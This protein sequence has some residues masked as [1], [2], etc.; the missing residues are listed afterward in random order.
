MYYNWGHQDLVLWV[1]K[2]YFY[3][4]LPKVMLCKMCGCINQMSKQGGS[5]NFSISLT[6]CSFSKKKNT[7]KREQLLKE[8]V[9]THQLVI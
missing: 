5:F 2:K 8:C 4:N 3:Y 7:V 9:F 1:F 6:A